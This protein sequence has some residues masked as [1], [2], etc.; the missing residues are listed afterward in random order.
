MIGRLSAG[1]A[2]AAL[3]A[4]AQW[5]A[6]NPV[7]KV[8]RL[9]N[10]VEF[11]QQTGAMRIE[12][13][14]D[15]IVRMLYS[16]TGAVTAPRNPVVVK[17]DW[18]P[19]EFKLDD[20]A[21]EA[22]ITTA[23]LRI[24]VNKE[25]GYV[26]Y[27]DAAGKQLLQDGPKTMTPKVV[28]GEK[29]WSAEDVVA[30]YGSPE[31]LYGLG[32]HQ[33]GVWNYR[34]ES[35]DITQENTNIAVPFLASTNGY[36]LFWNNTGASRF[37]NR[38]VHYLYV[39][40]EVAD[41]IDYY[42]IYGPEFDRLIAAYRELTGAAP[43]FGKWAYGFW[44]CKNK[45]QTQ[46]ELLSIAREYREKHIPVDNIVQDWFWWTNTGEFKFNEKYPDP[47]GMMDELH[48]KH[49]HLMMSVWPYFYPGSATYDDM[50]R[51][52]FFIDRTKSKSFHPQ[53]MALYDAFNP[54]AR[55]YYWNEINRSLFQ[56][57]ADAW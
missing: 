14:T 3:C 44:Q 10:G 26:V 12:I 43:M 28:N 1:F 30:M 4:S 53:G 25:N 41:V 50:D 49:F 42:F 19:A 22:V 51:K 57:G 47:R 35:V 31:A 17:N 16:P 21:R 11:T 38:F 13:C 39:S 20:G 34:G 24:A 7:T 40:A 46:A 33:A 48:A 2:L 36:A 32:Q 54:E 18:A 6:F 15:S 52:G 9:A 37:N 27:R 8:S 5:Y 45:Y 55:K 29:T 23:R 56:I